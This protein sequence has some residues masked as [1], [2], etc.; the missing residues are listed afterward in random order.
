M[1]IAYVDIALI[2]ADSERRLGLL[3][4]WLTAVTRQKATLFAILSKALAVARY[5]RI[6]GLA[7][8]YF[9]LGYFL[10]TLFY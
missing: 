1:T 6:A 3:R 8:Y 10:L 4:T 2:V 7:A 5:E 9:Y